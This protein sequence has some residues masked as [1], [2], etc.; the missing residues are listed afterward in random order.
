MKVKVYLTE[1]QTY[2]FP[3]RSENNG[4]EIAGRI[5]REGLWIND[6]DGN[7]SFYPITRIVKAKLIK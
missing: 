5:V 1:N 6:E 3:A 7:E 2:E 4:R